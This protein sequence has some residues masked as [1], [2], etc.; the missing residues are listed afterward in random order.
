M[1]TERWWGSC[2][3]RELPWTLSPMYVAHF[4]RTE[5]HRMRRCG[6]LLAAAETIYQTG[7]RKRGVAT[8]L[9]ESSVD[10]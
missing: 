8:W 10:P 4:T 2:W 1:G 7:G 9:V 3:L 5:L 6:Q